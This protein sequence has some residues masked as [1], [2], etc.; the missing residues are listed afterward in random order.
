MVKK[1]D[2]LVEVTLAVGIFSMIAI[3]IV[4]VMS[5][6]VA[7]AQTALETTLT[8]E[9]I[10]TQAEAIRFI[11]SSYIANVNQKENPYAELWNAI[12]DKAKTF[13]LA[14]EDS[15]IQSVVQFNPSSCEDLYNPTTSQTIGHAFIINP[16]KLASLNDPSKVVISQSQDSNMFRPASTYPRLVYTDKT[17]DG[18]GLLE[19][20]EELFSVEGIYVIA[21]KDNNTTAIGNDKSS[22]FYDFY[23][24]TCWYGNK[25][26]DASTIS[27]VMRLYDPNIV[28]DNSN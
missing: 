10:D 5:N 17:N 12:V 6:G 28:S 27:T 23:I 18:E 25:S 4:A 3:A 1:G 14:P 9:E 2:T 22:A 7:S 24:R 11:H 13:E 20:K 21:V 15:E 19:R 16:R 26:S 8:R